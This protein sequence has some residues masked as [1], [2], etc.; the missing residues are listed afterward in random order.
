MS[1]RIDDSKVSRRSFINYLLG[2]G[3]VATIVS[4]LYP[5]IGFIMPPKVREVVKSSVLAG[6]VGDLAPNSGKIFRFG[7]RPGILV[8]TPQGELKAF[9]AICTHL[10]CVVQYRED[11]GHIWCACHN[12]HYDLNGV[13]IAGPPPRPLE[14]YKVDVR[15]EEIVASKKA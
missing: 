12:G 9:S 2:G 15:G 5:L 3:V 11:L 10:A 7:D 13:N 1:A 14:E 4:A 6:K 8:K